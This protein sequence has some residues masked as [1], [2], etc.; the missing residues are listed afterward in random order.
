MLKNIDPETKGI[1]VV[2]SV[3]LTFVLLGGLIDAWSKR[4]DI[5]YICHGDLV[6]NTKTNTYECKPRAKP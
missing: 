2:L 4:A 3:L 6:A 1:V 5:T